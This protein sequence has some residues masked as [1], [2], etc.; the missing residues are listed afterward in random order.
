[1]DFLDIWVE[2]L[3]DETEKGAI[4]AIRSLPEFFYE[5]DFEKAEDNYRQYA[6]GRLPD[7][8][9]VVARTAEEVLGVVGATKRHDA[10][11]VYFLASFAVKK[12]QRGGGI[13]RRL[14][15]FLEEELRKKDGRLVFAETTTASYCDST[16]AFYEAVGYTMTAEVPDFWTDGD[17]L[18]LYVKRL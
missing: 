15:E 10:N 4:E 6:A 14:L 16:R 11:G 9:F 17:P 12:G 18:A 7:S 8:V 2:R 1:M 5:R 13:G 3:S